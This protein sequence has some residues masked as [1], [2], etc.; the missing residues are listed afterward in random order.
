MALTPLPSPDMITLDSQEPTYRKRKR[1]I[2]VTPPTTAEDPE[3][4]QILGGAVNVLSVNATAI[5]HVARLYETDPNARRGML[6]AVEAVAQS[7]LNRGKLVICAVG[8]SGFIA[9]QLVAMLKSFSISSSFMH[10]TE[11][12][13]GDL[14]DIYEVR[15]KFRMQLLDVANFDPRR[16]TLYFSYRT[17]AEHR[18]Y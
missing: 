3:G 7:T 15:L 2:P 11:A 18:N 14:G 16:M 12:V 4:A 5:S 13:H 1:S 9:Q 8:K 6:R 17:A 10:A